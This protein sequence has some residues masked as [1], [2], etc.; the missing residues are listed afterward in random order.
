[1]NI[2]N[3]VL[4][5]IRYKQLYCYGHVQR[6]EKERINNKEWIDREEWRRKTKHLYSVHNCNNNNTNIS[7]LR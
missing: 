5:Y 6:M 7:L 4:D 2:K 1:M 3:S